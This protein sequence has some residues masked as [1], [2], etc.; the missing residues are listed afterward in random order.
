[1]IVNK[2]GE[3]FF[4]G[5]VTFHGQ[6]LGF[7]DWAV[8]TWFLNLS[9]TW[10]CETSF[11]MALETLYLVFK[12]L[13]IQIKRNIYICN[14]MC[15]CMKDTRDNQRLGENVSSSYLY[16]FVSELSSWLIVNHLGTHEILYIQESFY[17]I[18]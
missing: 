5:Y 6:L 14:D 15:L 12:L 18:M 13:L 9:F 7:W 10:T 8:L 16:V 3:N 17:V 11:L 2:V 4:K 1:M